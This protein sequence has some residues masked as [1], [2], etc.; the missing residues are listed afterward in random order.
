M[1]SGIMDLKVAIYE[2]CNVSSGKGFKAAIADSITNLSASVSYLIQLF[3]PSL[4]SRLASLVVSVMCWSRFIELTV[5]AVVS[6]LTVCD[7]SSGAG[8]NSNAVRGIR[9]VAALGLSG[10][11]IML[12][13]F[14]CQQIQYG[15]LSANVLDGVGFMSCVWKEIVV[16]I[17]E[18]GLVVRAPS[19]AK[20]VLG[21]G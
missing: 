11:V 3:I 14:I 9:N 17:V 8:M 2:D 7:I 20:Q 4:I 21:M 16:G 19:L 1:S 5:M 12:S 15:I 6:P 10:A 18:V 13:V